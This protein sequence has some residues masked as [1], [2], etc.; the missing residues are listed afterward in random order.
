MPIELDAGTEVMPITQET[1]AQVPGELRGVVLEK[2]HEWLRDVRQR[3]RQHSDAAHARLVAKFRYDP[4]LGRRRA[5]AQC[6]RQWAQRVR[7]EFLD[8]DW[9][10]TR[11]VYRRRRRLLRELSNASPRPEDA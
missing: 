9:A 6:A 8:P 10:G 7:E 11:T 2:Y 5:R 1:M 4:L 3:E